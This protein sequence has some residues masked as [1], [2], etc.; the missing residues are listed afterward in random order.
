MMEPALSVRDLTVAY[1]EQP[2][3]WDLDLDIPAGSMAAIIG[4]N[5]AGKST[6]LKAALDLVPRAAGTVRFFGKPYAEARAR[7]GYVPQRSTVDWD[8]PIDVL[9]VVTMGRYAKLGWFKRPGRADREAALHCLDRVGMA[10]FAKRHISQL[11][12]GQQQR[13]FLARALAQEA[14]FTI[15]DEPFAGVDATTEHAIIGVLR[16]LKAE[17]K[18][19]LAVHHDLET[20]ADYFDHVT[21]LNVRL[22]ANGPTSTTLN[23]ENLVKTY[24]ARA[25]LLGD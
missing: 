2:V 1:A 6:L 21:L 13:V 25:A 14:D 4:P 10:E 9:D 20:A 12:G 3:L 8:F 23:R 17:G 16:E 19:I 5:G 24:G 15:L 7:L 22:V 11:S 18:T